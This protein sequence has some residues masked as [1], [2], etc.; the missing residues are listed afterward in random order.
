VPNVVNEPYL[1]YAPGSKER[2]ALLVALDKFRPTVDIPCVLGGKEVRTGDLGT[3]VMPFEHK[4]VVSTYHQVTDAVAQQ[5]I[6]AAMAAKKRWEG[7]P[8]EDRAAVFLKAA[9]LLATKYR[10]EV[11]AAVMIGTG[12]N[13]WQA[14]IDVVEA[15]DFWR[16]GVKFAE[17]IYSAQ[18]P[19]NA[20]GNWNYMEHRPLEGFIT[21]ISPFNFVA[22]G[23]NLPSAPAIMGNTSVWKPSNTALLGNYLLYQILVEAGLPEGV[24]N[25][26]PGDGKVLGRHTFSHRDFGG[27]HFTG[28]TA[29][30]NALWKEIADN[31]TKY[32]SYPRIVGETGGKNFHFVHESAD[33]GQVVFHSIRSA[34]EYSGQKCSACSRAYIPRKSFDKFKSQLVEQMKD[35]KLGDPREFDTFMSAVIDEV[36]FKKITEGIEAAKQSSDCEII[37]GGGY[38]SDVGYYVEP[39]VIVTRDPCFKTMREE[40]FGPVLTVFVYDENKFEETLDLCNESTYALT[41]AVFAQDRHVLRYASDRLRHAAGNMYLNDKSTGSIVGQQPFGG[42]R[43]SGTNDK[44]G[45]GLNLMRWVSPRV[46]KETFIPVSG[47]KYPHMDH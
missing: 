41:G 34:F 35:I 25:F 46:I 8:W 40:L 27:L 28:S 36:A 14:E 37:A 31:L 5:A 32:K 42:S 33:V 16:L 18:P 47:W 24:I 13:V 20:P 7:M 2:N 21:A 44:S 26:L 39:T 43:L 19:F 29:T 4:S 12:K 45:S 38:S 23:A 9:D 10:A 11:C 1:H 22:I 6:D 17:Q 15:I 3:Q 30:F